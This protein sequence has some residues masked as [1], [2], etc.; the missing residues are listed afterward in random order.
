MYDSSLTGLVLFDSGH[1]ALMSNVGSQNLYIEQSHPFQEVH[2]NFIHW[3]DTL[4]NLLFFL[5]SYI[6]LESLSQRME[7]N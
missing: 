6:I 2:E 5:G 1:R 7:L 4:F 3:R